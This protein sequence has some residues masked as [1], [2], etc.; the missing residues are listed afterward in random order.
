MQRAGPE[1][2]RLPLEKVEIRR[3]E[4]EK[5]EWMGTVSD[6]K[7]LAAEYRIVRSR[8]EMPRH[9]RRE[10]QHFRC[11]LCLSRQIPNPLGRFDT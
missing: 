7:F 9:D 6:V 5:S 4:I 8:S 10:L 1:S 11:D 2:E 3:L